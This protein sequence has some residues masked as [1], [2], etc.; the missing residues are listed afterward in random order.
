MKGLSLGV[1]IPSGAFAIPRDPG[2]EVLRAIRQLQATYQGPICSQITESHIVTYHAKKLR[3][4]GSWVMPS[5]VAY[6]IPKNS[7]GFPIKYEIFSHQGLKKKSGVLCVQWE[8][9][10]NNQ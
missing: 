4:E 2:W 5:I 9:T 8:P 6:L 7:Q 10:T 1:S 3:H